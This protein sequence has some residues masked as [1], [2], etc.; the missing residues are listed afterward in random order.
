MRP[1]FYPSLVN[2]RFGDPAVFVDFLMERRA[3]LFDLGDIAALPPRAVLRLSDIFV[4]HAHIDHF[5]GFDRL[6]R[7]LVGRARQVR[8]Y[9]PAGYIDR[10]EA[11]LNGYTWNLADRYEADLVFIVTEVPGDGPAA[12]ARFRLTRR[13][14]GG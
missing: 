8:L 12:R 11:K 9:G 5:V 14:L 4:S 1:R 10:V 6:L 2:D 13:I 7:L 3:I